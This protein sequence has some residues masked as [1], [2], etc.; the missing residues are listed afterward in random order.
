MPKNVRQVVGPS[1]LEGSRGTPIESL[2]LKLAG[3]DK[4]TI[5][6]YFTG[7]FFFGITPKGLL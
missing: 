5:K 7:L 3:E 4:S 1:S 6:Q 2:V